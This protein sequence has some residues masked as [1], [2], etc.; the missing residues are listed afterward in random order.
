MASLHLHTQHQTGTVFC[1]AVNF[2]NGSNCTEAG[3]NV[4]LELKTHYESLLHT[5]KRS[6]KLEMLVLSAPAEDDIVGFSCHWPTN[7]VEFGVL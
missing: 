7:G 1:E 4:A 5:L 2:G 6:Q 3:M